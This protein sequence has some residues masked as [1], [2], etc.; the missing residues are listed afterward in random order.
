[1]TLPSELAD[2]LVERLFGSQRK[3]TPQEMED[4]TP[5][6]PPRSVRDQIADQRKG[7]Q[8]TRQ[9]MRNVRLY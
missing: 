2:R 3:F 9:K 7:R 6:S 5:P 1:M 4:R 8:E